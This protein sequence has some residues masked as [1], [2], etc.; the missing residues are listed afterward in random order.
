MSSFAP[1]SW[2]VLIDR[3]K[4]RKNMKMKNKIKNLPENVKKISAFISAL[5]VIFT[6]CGSLLNWFEMKMTEHLDARI[7]SVETTINDIR[8]DTIRLQLDNLINNDS[9]NIESILK[10]AKVYFIDMNGD[11]YMTE[12]FKKWG[13]D[14]DVDLSDFNFTSHAID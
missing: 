4:S 12:K 1:N 3:P 6:A 9:D 10:V 5:I 13:K 11:W 2:A 14:H 8:E 7:S